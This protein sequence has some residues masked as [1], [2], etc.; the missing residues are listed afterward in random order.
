MYHYIPAMIQEDNKMENNNMSNEEKLAKFLEEIR[1]LGN[2]RMDG[3]TPSMEKKTIDQQAEE[4]IEAISKK[5][6]EAEK[7][8]KNIVNEPAKDTKVSDTAADKSHTNEIGKDNIMELLYK[9]YCT[10]NSDVSKLLAEMVSCED[11]SERERI[12]KRISNAYGSEKRK[13]FKAGFDSA[14]ELLK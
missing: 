3:E 11:K 7:M 13:A 5:V 4:V 10:R 8:V 12:A 14:K 6:G 9:E 1:K 2:I